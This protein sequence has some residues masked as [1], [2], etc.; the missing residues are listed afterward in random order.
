[1][2]DQAGPEFFAVTAEALAIEEILASGHSLP[3]PDEATR[4]LRYEWRARLLQTQGAVEQVIT[5]RDHF[6]PVAES[7]AERSPKQKT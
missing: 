4:V 3:I 7:L 5:Y 1:L 2:R 6:L